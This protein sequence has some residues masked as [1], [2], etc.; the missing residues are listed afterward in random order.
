M[1]CNKVHT[2]M[3]E[4]NDKKSTFTAK[5]NNKQDCPY[6]TKNYRSGSREREAEKVI[7]RTYGGCTK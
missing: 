6:A 7:E 3:E 5:D 1:V 2:I 4:K